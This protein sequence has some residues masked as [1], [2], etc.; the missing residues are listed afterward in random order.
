MF[1]FLSL[2]P[3]WSPPETEAR[4]PFVRGGDSWFADKWPGY[5]NVFQGCYLVITL[6]RGIRQNNL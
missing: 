1:L 6:S 4:T 3:W 2:F 5:T